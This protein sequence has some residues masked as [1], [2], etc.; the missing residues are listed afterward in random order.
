MERN[1]MDPKQL[2]HEHALALA[3]SS[4]PYWQARDTILN[5]MR[6]MG[7]SAARLRR[8]AWKHCKIPRRRVDE[9]LSGDRKEWT[10][11]MLWEWSQL[12]D[13]SWKH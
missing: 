3:K 7:V 5:R 8:H 1:Q 11:H 2:A 10:G 4:L 6:A 13:N 12:V 9:V